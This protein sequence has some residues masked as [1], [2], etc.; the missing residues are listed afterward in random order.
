MRDEQ[1]ESFVSFRVSQREFQTLERRTVIN[2]TGAYIVSFFFPT[3]PSNSNRHGWTLTSQKVESQVINCVN[4][5][6]NVICFRVVTIE[7]NFR[8]GFR[9]LGTTKIP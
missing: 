6:I 8:F 9:R 2:A 5:K 3:R 1:Q 7:V 4:F